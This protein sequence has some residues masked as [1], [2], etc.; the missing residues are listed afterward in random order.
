MAWPAYDWMGVAK[1]AL[2]STSRYLAREL[3]PKR[4]RVNLVAAGPV[5]TMAA[6]SI[7]GFS[8]FEDVWADRAPLGWD[9]HDSSAVAKACVALHVGLVPADDR[10]DGPRRRRLPRHRCLTRRT[11]RD[12]TRYALRIAH[13]FGGLLRSGAFPL[14]HLDDGRSP[15]T[16]STLP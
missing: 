15:C 11:E 3:G 7:P 4:I 2:E 9:V 12:S 14:R 10:R 16:R 5:R 13:E 6:K 8:K 1:A